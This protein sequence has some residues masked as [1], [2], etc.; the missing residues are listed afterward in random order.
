MFAMF[1]E[2][3]VKKFS[4]DVRPL[5]EARGGGL[6]AAREAQSTQGKQPESPCDV[7]LSN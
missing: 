7:N 4:T 3:I 1:H 6:I 2:I 5:K